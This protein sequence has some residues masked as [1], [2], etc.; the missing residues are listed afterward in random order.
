MIRDRFAMPGMHATDHVF[1]LP[2]DHARPDGPT[3]AV[4]ARELVADERRGEA[5]PVL[6]YLQGGPGSEAPRPTSASGW[7]GRALKDFRVLLLDQRGTG[8]SSPVTAQT[9][10]ELG[11]A[12]AQAE[13]LAHF[14][15]DAIV[16]DAEAIRRQL[17]GEDGRWT[18]LGQS[19]GGFCALRYLSAAPQGLERAL[20]TGGLA[21]LTRPAD[22]V[23]RA[24]YRRLRAR[25]DAYLVRYPG[26][27]QGWSEVAGYLLEHDVRLPDGVRLTV[28]RLQF[29]G[30][31]LGR[32]DGFEEL[33]YLLEG[34]FVTAGGQRVLAEPFVHAV[35]RRQGFVDNPL[36]AAL[37]E[38]IYAQG[39][40]TAWAAQRLR[41]EQPDLDFAATGSLRFT[42]EMIYPWM[43]E[44][45]PSLAPLREA[46][47]L[48]AAKADWPRLY[49]VEALA[50][51]EVPVAAL[52]YL[53]DIYVDYGFSRETAE[54]VGNLRLWSTDEYQHNGLR[55][56][57]ERILERLL[58][59]ARGPA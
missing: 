32:S 13:H 43:F 12:S 41:A 47:E 48:L 8:R 52:A 15:A 46:A 58:A 57:G 11:D 1:E 20:I 2:L 17:L 10:P 40:A 6:L 44:Q 22:D 36:F 33:H 9:L 39:R 23:Y 38:A 37:H 51:N 3:L 45:F 4:F 49:D 30:M 21:S 53:D 42:G 14:R 29:L 50:A 25:N 34:A 5:L 24:T 27:A 55:A 54:A 18:I 35:Y 7:I 31:E 26:D 56:D 19:F 16:D 28:E 59:M